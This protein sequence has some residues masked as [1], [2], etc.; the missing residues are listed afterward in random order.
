MAN[1]D[2]DDLESISNQLREICIRNDDTVQ[3]LDSSHVT[4]HIDVYQAGALFTPS[5]PISNTF[6]VNNGLSLLL[7]SPLGAAAFSTPQSDLKECCKDATCSV[8]LSPMLCRTALIETRCKV[9]ETTLV[10]MK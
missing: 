4:E 9:L 10:I 7:T 1:D 8:C 3:Q 6:H 5:K 2:Q